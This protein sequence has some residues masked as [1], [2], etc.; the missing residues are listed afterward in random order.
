MKQIIGLDREL[1]L[2]WLDLAA[3]RAVKERDKVA[4]RAQ[5]MDALASDIP[6]HFVRYKT[7]TV[8]IRTWLTVPPE[9]TELRNRAL[10]LLK[11]ATA[12]QRLV[13]HWGMLLLAYPFFRQVVTIVGRNAEMGAPISRIQTN[14]KIAEKWGDRYSVQ[15]AVLRVFQSL[16]AW[17]VLARSETS[18]AFTPA[19]A[20]DIVDIQLSLWLVE[21]TLRS[22]AVETPFS[23]AVRAPENFPF[24]LR[25]TLTQATRS[26]HFETFREGKELLIGARLAKAGSQA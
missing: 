23:V 4:L 17:G 25:L 12:D 5:L 24:R 3:T 15:R 26:G 10:E 16:V 13:L 19:P 6:A 21:V 14:R 11:M 20:R 18:D 8:L 9:E 1:E 7:C 2:R 22:R